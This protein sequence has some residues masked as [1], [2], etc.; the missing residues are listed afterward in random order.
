MKDTFLKNITWLHT[1]MALVG[2][3]LHFKASTGEVLREEPPTGCGCWCSGPAGD[4]RLTQSV[5]R[6]FATPA[7]DR[8]SAPGAFAG[9]RCAY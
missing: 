6:C 9:H 2:Q 1:W 5:R 4:E 3:A 8:V 7:G